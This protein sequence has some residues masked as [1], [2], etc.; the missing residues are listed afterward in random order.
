MGR[1]G[2]SDSTAKAAG[3]LAGGVTLVVVAS[4][5]GK[6]LVNL[7]GPLPENP[8]VGMLAT[9]GLGVVAAAVVYVGARRLAAMSRALLA[10]VLAVAAV[11]VWVLLPRQI[12]VTESWVPR[13][14]ERYSC[15]GW[16]FRHYPPE[17]FD[18]SATTY[19]VGLEHRIAD[20]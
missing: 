17:T 10:V 7:Y 6:L 14:N 11:A 13:P 3:G 19:C 5:A 1:R 18:A 12:D 20:G 2:C 4:V 16:T 15:T 8:F 9:L